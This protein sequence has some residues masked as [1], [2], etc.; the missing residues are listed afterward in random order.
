MDK[1]EVVLRLSRIKAYLLHEY[2]YVSN[3]ALINQ[4]ASKYKNDYY[5]AAKLISRIKEE[6]L[7]G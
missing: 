6:V 4:D 5:E 3:Y 1:Y 2:V 7:N